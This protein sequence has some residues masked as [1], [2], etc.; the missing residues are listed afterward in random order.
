MGYRTWKVIDV[1]PGCFS[2]K[3]RK[4]YLYYSLSVFLLSYS[5]SYNVSYSYINLESII[6]TV[7]LIKLVSENAKLTEWLHIIVR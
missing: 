4:G 5:K 7:S 2:G 1:R 6:F 3:Q